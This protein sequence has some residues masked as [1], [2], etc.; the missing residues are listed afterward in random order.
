MSLAHSIMGDGYWEKDS[1]TI[2]ICTENF[3]KED[4]ERF[5]LFLKIK[6]NLFATTKKRNQKGYRIRFSSKKDNLE[7]LR[8]LVLPYMHSNMTYKLGI[9]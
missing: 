6:F 5:I 4:V 8:K 2:F 3:R 7:N 9:L 1:K